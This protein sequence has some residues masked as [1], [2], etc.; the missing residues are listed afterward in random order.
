MQAILTKIIPCSNT[1]PTRIK[2]I[3]ARGSIT[4]SADSLCGDK[5]W[6]SEETHIASADKLIA[7]FCAEDEKN[8]GS[9]PETN[10]WNRPRSCGQLPNGDYAHVFNVDPPK[11]VEKEKWEAKRINNDANG[12]PRYVVHFLAFLTDEDRA[13]TDSQPGFGV[14]AKYDRALVRARKV[15]GRKF[16]NKQ[17][18][19]GI[20]FQCYGQSEIDALID[21]ARAISL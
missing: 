15:G 20:V 10:P 12:N 2:A 13:W 7:K 17:F 18:G 1:K 6:G 5:G 21:Q 3:C 9:N 8:Y 4:L 14:T 16:H 19:G 11:P